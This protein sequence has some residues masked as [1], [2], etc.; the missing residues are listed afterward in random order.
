MADGPSRARQVSNLAI[1]NSIIERPHQRRPCSKCSAPIAAFIASRSFTRQS[2]VGKPTEIIASGVRKGLMDGSDR[3]LGFLE[4]AAPTNQAGL[5]SRGRARSCVGKSQKTKSSRCGAKPFETSST[6]WRL[7]ITGSPFR[8]HIKSY[9]KQRDARSAA[10]VRVNRS[11]IKAEFRSQAFNSVSCQCLGPHR[12]CSCQ[13][14]GSW[15]PSSG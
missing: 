2:I 8:G 9:E 12:R 6:C 4:S 3:S 13:G 5:P 14:L 7:R 11:E 10:P 15:K 1:S